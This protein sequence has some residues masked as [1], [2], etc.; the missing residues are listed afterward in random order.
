[1]PNVQPSEENI[2]FPINH[3]FFGTTMRV[4]HE[5]SPLVS[6]NSRL[7]RDTLNASIDFKQFGTG[8]QKI[9]Y[10]FLILRPTNKNHKER[11]KYKAKDKS[12]SISHRLPY[13]SVANNTLEE[14][15]PLMANA[16]LQSLELGDLEETILDFDYAGLKQAIRDL[17]VEQ[18]WVS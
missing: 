2:S 9:Y 8:I 1:M 16:L 12:L 11:V 3:D 15:L 10:C 7:I 18:G 14:N 17:F 4:W 5:V 13:A 6:A